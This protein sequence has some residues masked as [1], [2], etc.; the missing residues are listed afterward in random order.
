MNDKMDKSNQT[1]SY[2][3]SAIEKSVA[4]IQANAEMIQKSSETME[5]SIIAMEESQ[6]QLRSL[7]NLFQGPSLPWTVFFLTSLL[8]LPSF[9]VGYSMRRLEKTLKKKR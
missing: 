7:T 4:A 9:V 5:A 6:L 8:L 1:I 2:N 3:T